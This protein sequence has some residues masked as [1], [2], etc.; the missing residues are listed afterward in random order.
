MG[1]RSTPKTVRHAAPK[2]SSYAPL[3]V[4]LS[5]QA[6]DAI[7]LSFV[8]IETILGRKLPPT[9]RKHSAWWSNN[10]AGYNQPQCSWLDVGWE[11]SQVNVMAGSVV[12]R[13]NPFVVAAESDLDWSR[14]AAG[15]PPEDALDDRTEESEFVPSQSDTREVVEVTIRQRRGQQA[16]RDQLR[17]RYGD[18]CLVTGFKI[19][20]IL[21]AAH[22]TPYRSRSDHDP[23]NGLLLR[24]DIHTLFDLNLLGIEPQSMRIELHPKLTAEYGALAGSCLRCPGVRRPSQDALQ[25]RYVHFLQ[26]LSHA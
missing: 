24:C 9:A 19:L 11:T 23:R 6:E 21:E 10:E 5:Q 1:R 7:K 12:F 15:L 25:V 26:R 22:I 20:D 3:A 18:Q 8:R 13:R 17:R 16:F 2:S 14:S 4:Y